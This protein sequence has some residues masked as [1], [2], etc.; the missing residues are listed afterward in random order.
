MGRMMKVVG[1]SYTRARNDALLMRS[2]PLGQCPRECEH[3]GGRLLLYVGIEGST[4][5]VMADFG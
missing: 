2:G 3:C 1:N 5:I 4:A